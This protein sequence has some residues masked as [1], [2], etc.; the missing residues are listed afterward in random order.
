MWVGCILII[1]IFV[2]I[3]FK[4]YCKLR[5]D[6]MEF[7][8]VFVECYVWECYNIIKILI[9]IWLYGIVVM[10]FLMVIWGLFNF[11]LGDI[12]CVLNW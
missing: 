3:F 7:E 9:G 1:V 10:F 12:V 8:I 11:E 6:V 4:I 5:D 2:L